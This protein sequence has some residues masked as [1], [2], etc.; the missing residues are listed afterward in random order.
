M[1]LRLMAGQRFLEPYVGVRVPEGQPSVG[2]SESTSAV[3]LTAL[4]LLQRLA[5]RKGYAGVP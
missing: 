4:L 3:S 5:P 2:K 1:P